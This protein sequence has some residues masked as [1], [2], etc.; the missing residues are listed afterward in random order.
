VSQGEKQVYAHE[1]VRKRGYTLDYRKV[2]AA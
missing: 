2:M 1:M